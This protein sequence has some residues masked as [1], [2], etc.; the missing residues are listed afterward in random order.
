M[1][2]VCL[3][4]RISKIRRRET[5]RLAKYALRSLNQVRRFISSDEL[6][7]QKHTKRSYKSVTVVEITAQHGLDIFREEGHIKRWPPQLEFFVVFTCNARA[8]SYARWHV[9]PSRSEFLPGLFVW[10]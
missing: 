3:R 7:V 1:R 9:L 2:I 8:C 6:I 5:S 10:Q 4:K